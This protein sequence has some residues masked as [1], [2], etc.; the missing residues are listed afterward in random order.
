MVDAP[1]LYVM[2]SKVA[3]DGTDAQDWDTAAS[4]KGD[5]EVKVTDVTIAN[6]VGLVVP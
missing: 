2:A 6:K 5:R 1:K 3:A 4:G